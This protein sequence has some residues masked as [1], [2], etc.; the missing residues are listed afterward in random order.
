MEVEGYGGSKIITPISHG[1]NYSLIQTTVTVTT[2]VVTVGFYTDSRGGSNLCIDD[3]YLCGKQ[4][5][6]PSFEYGSLSGWATWQ[7]SWQACVAE[8][9][10]GA[11]Y[12]GSYKCEIASDE[13]YMQ[14]V[15]RTFENIPN[16][17]YTVSALVKLT[18][19]SNI[20]RMELSEYGGNTIYYPIDESND[21]VR[22]LQT[23][24]VTTGK[25]TVGFYVD[26]PGNTSLLIDDV[27]ATKYM[28]HFAN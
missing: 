28:E 4:I 27:A 19:Q 12:N 14:G 2:G 10:A 5:Y 21:Y 26:A 3:L 13:Q 8:V 9:S 16:G 17:L 7:P 20:C 15:Y 18:N 23:V 24:S 6:N 22:I 1:T 11:A 25:L